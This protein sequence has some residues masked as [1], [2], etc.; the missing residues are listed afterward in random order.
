M[1]LPLARRF[2]TAR[3][4]GPL[5][6]SLIHGWSIASSSGIVPMAMTAVSAITAT[7]SQISY[8]V[9]RSWVMRNTVRPSVSCSSRVSRSNAAAPIGSRPAVGSSRNSNSGSSASARARP[10]RFFM[11]PD[12]S[13]GILR[14]GVFGQSRQHDLEAGDFVAQ[15]SLDLGIELAQRHL[16]V[17]RD[18]Q[19]REQRAAL[20]QHAPARADVDIVVVPW[21]R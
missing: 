14:A 19:G 5:K 12:S 13:D 15:L 18:R 1:V 6:Y 4:R 9:S 10:A 7:R 11:P 17:L 2:C 16:D 20:E 21:H 8:S 3:P